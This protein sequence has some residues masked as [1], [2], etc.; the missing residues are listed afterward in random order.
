MIGSYLD[1]TPW[2]LPVTVAAC[3]LLLASA[4]P[5]ARRLR[6]DPAWIVLYGTA[7]AGFLGVVATP[8]RWVP[9]GHEAA[10]GDQG[11]VRQL[12]WDPRLPQTLVSSANQDTLN[13][14]IAAPMAVLAGWALLR[15]GL[16]WPVAVAVAAP[17]AA[18]G[19]QWLF[20]AFGRVAFSVG[21]LTCNLTGVA[22]GLAVGALA[23]W[24]S[25]TGRCSRCGPGSA[26]PAP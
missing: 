12:V 18:E 21:D 22:A 10:S 1:G 5:L 2:A 26:R 4:R 11:G 14:W 6:A 7:V 17:F 19:V 16:R 25:A 3:L 9:A 24:A 13:A 8:D 23:G 15:S 20:P